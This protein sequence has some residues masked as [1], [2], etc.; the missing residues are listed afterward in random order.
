MSKSWGQFRP[1]M[2]TWLRIHLEKNSVE[3]YPMS[4][5]KTS[6]ELYPM[7]WD[8]KTTVEL[9]PMRWDIK[10]QCRVISE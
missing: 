4:W 9:Y 8:I 10:N 3:L 1:L 7:R 5:E 2:V 6:V